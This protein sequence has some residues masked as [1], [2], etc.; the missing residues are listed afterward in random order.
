MSLCNSFVHIGVGALLWF[1]NAPVTIMSTVHVI[2]STVE[3]M[4]KQPGKKSMNAEKAREAF[5]DLTQ[6]AMAILQCI[7]H[8]N[9]HMG[10]ID[11]ANQVRSY[12]DTRLTFF[13][14]W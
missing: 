6:K 9:H 5:G 10:V 3:F 14:T 11:I 4:R 8:Y 13:R 12:Y 2:A 1:D 7:D